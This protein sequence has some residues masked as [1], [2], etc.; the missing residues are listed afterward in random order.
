MPELELAAGASFGRP[1]SVGNQKLEAAGYK[2]VHAIDV[3]DTDD[4]YIFVY[5]KDSPEKERFTAP[6][7]RLLWEVQDEDGTVLDWWIYEE[8][9]AAP[10]GE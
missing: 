6:P 8:I 3:N 5:E 10:I 7:P 4:S 9:E 1:K 2:L